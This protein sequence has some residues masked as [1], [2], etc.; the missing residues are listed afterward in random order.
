MRLALEHMQRGLEF[1]YQENYKLALNEYEIVITLLPNLS[2]GH[3]RLGS[4]YYKLKNIEKARYHWAKALELNPENSNLKIFL[5]QVT[6][7]KNQPT[8]SPPSETLDNLMF[9]E[10]D[11]T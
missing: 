3:A 6:P 7:Q 9:I 4:I 2:I 10:Q 8:N 5:Q 1:Y 11:R